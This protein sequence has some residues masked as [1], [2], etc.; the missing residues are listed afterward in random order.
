[1]SVQV[2]QSEFVHRFVPGAEPSGPTLLLLHGTGGNEDD[3]LPIGPM[4]APGAAL[5]SPRGKML[6]SGMP[7]FFRRFAEGQFDQQDLLFRTAELAG[8]IQW[9]AAKYG[10]DPKQLYAVGFSNGANIA[11]SLLLRHPE[12]L[13]GGIL[14][15]GM[16]P[17]RLAEP[18]DLSGKPVLL[19]NGK[20]DPIAPPAEADALRSILQSANAAVELHWENAGHGLTSGDLTAARAW[21]SDKLAKVPVGQ[22]GRRQ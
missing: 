6:E 3:L 15:R 11:S 19:L 1:M 14:I 16:V 18:V 5:L 13:G 22:I 20:L 10:F 9:A 8:F 17:F 7:R 4:I 12:A 21:L 2:S